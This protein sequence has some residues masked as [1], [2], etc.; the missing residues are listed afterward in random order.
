MDM[1][2]IVLKAYYPLLA[3]LQ[4]RSC[5]VVGGGNVAERK[6]ASLLEVR[7]AVTVVSPYLTAKLE[8]WAEIGLI[9]VHRRTYEAG[10]SREAFF[11]LAC[12]DSAEVNRQ[13]CEEAM[14]GGKL[15]NSAAPPE[16]GNVLL[17]ATVRRGRLLI[18][19]STSGASPSLAGTI[20]DRLDQEYGP[21]YEKYLDFLADFRQTIRQR[22]QD[23]QL[24]RRWLKD[25]LSWD[26]L[27]AIRSG[28]YEQL[29]EEKKRLL[30]DSTRNL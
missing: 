23:P 8:H 28:S 6:T 2:V 9:S 14:A 4:G 3:D 21:E 29:L 18:S 16:S 10:D 13:V 7:A 19:V 26:V 27:G 25:M 22:I 30:D 5:L 1:D 24:K 17:P 12:T 15:A 11:V 20:R